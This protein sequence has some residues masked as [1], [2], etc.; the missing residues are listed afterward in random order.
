[1][2]IL[3]SCT[4]AQQQNFYHFVSSEKPSTIKKVVNESSG[5]ELP[6]D[7]EEFIVVHG[8]S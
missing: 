6:S 5:S 3:E 4:P 8:C 7:L 1:M 2:V